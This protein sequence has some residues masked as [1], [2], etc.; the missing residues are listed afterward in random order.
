M[1]DVGFVEWFVYHDALLVLCE[2]IILFFSGLKC[3]FTEYLHLLYG[4][5]EY[6]ILISQLWQFAVK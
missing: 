2:V 3:Q 6:F 4:A 5:L 1:K